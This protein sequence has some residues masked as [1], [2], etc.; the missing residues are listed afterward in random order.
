MATLKLT[1]F[2]NHLEDFMRTLQKEGKIPTSTELIALFRKKQSKII[3]AVS[4]QLENVAIQKL[5]AEIGNRRRHKLWTQEQV[6]LFSEF[7]G[8]P[9]LI[10]GS[11]V[12]GQRGRLRKTLPKAPFGEVESWLE[13]EGRPKKTRRQRYRALSLLLKDMAPFAES[14]EMTFEEVFK[15][16]RASKKSKKATGAA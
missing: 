1:D 16:Y 7:P 14:M 8:L 12:L 15:A 13:E 5:V 3:E 10:I 9:Q 6:E 2:R 11:K 4:I